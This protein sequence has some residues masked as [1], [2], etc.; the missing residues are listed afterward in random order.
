MCA[1]PRFCRW[2]RMRGALWHHWH[3]FNSTNWYEASE[4][5]APPP[6]FNSFDASISTGI[7]EPCERY[8][9]VYHSS[10]GSHHT[11][12]DITCVPAPG[13]NNS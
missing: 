11:S 2:R 8:P 4:S 6:R 3:Q 10:S 12:D 5:A 1:L 9:A 7:S 13:C